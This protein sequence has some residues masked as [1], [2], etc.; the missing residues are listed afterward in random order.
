M[1]ITQEFLDNSAGAI[2]Q[3]SEKAK[4]EFW[5]CAG[6]LEMLKQLKEH[7]AKPEEAP[8]KEGNVASLTKA[9]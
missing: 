9:K 2:T 1:Q 6:V 8:A 3:Q 5:Q 7:L 4:Q